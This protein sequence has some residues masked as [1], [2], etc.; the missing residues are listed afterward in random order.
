MTTAQTYSGG[1]G[2]SQ[3]PYLIASKADMAA[4]ATAVNGGTTYSGR[5][6]LLTQNLT[7]I[8]TRIGN[9]GTNSFQ[10]TFD[11]GGY[12][13]NVNIA[14]ES[15]STVYAG[16]FGY[17][18]GATIKNLGV[19]GDISASSPG[20]SAYAGGIC[21][22]ADYSSISNCYATGNVSSSS[23]SSSYHSYA[24]GICGYVTNY[25]ISNCY[26][27]G[28][29]SSSSYYS[30]NSYAGGIC[31]YGRTINN[32]FAVNTN[33]T[34]NGSIGRIVANGDCTVEACY[35]LSSMLLNTATVSS[36]A[37]AGYNGKDTDVASFQ[38][39]AWNQDN[40]YW[41]FNDTWY[42]P[43]GSNNLPI[44]KKSPIIDFTLSPNSTTYGDLQ[45]IP[46]AATS[47]NTSA[48]IVYQSRNNDIAEVVGN[49]LTLKK[50]GA[51]TILATQTDGDGFK[52]GE[53]SCYLT[54]NK[55]EL[56]VQADTISMQYGET[57]PPF[58][59]KY[60]GFVNGE[61]SIVLSKLPTMQ[62]SSTDAGSRTIIPSGAEADN[63]TFTYRDGLLIISKR[64]LHVI[65]D[66]TSRTYGD[67]SYYDFTVHYDGFVNDDNAYSISRP[68]IST[69]ATSYSDVGEYVISCSGG[70]ATNY[71]F[72]YETGKLTIKKADL[73]VWVQDAWRKVGEAN[74]TFVL[75]Y[76]GFKN[77]DNQNVL[78]QLPTISCAANANSAAGFYD[79]TLSG[80]SDNHYNF[81]FP[82][83]SGRLEVTGDIYQHL[84]DSIS[85]YIAEITAL[86]AQLSNC[87]G[88]TV[89]PVKAATSS[90]NIYPN[91]AK[92]TV[93][94]Q[95]AAGKTVSFFNNSG[96]KVFEKEMLSDAETVTIASW[97]QGV[98]LVRILD[99]GN[100]VGVEK[101]I[102][103]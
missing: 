12:I 18:S 94:I 38:S 85:G 9:S 21:G 76:S 90:Q 15:S 60:N 70:Y 24:G 42:V 4:L 67:Y 20:N 54:I 96:S 83:Y 77:N 50:A 53:D 16:V 58:T 2:T 34:S 55:K 63:Y 29:V 37:T 45:Q 72:I 89:V 102:K 100:V 52:A 23:S 32:C 13:L 36:Q 22:Y 46:L 95:N 79:I 86:Q 75:R 28:N 33:I 39:Q 19:E 64:D 1:S 93:T 81:Q 44:L 66:S 82:N 61:D 78:D 92:G 26:A 57:L 41:D 65:P 73:N 7:G 74:P 35:A 101:L 17:I 6:F 49:I 14:I 3:D 56:I 25:S 5:Y 10:G 31:G 88:N 30:N 69:T 99:G 62:P 97:A 48:T 87:S 27:T 43:N 11:G 47:N 51:V 80:G 103:E 91:P 40:L 68:T 98:Y 84:R 71:N 59:C 8:T